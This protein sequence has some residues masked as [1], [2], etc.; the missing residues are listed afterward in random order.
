MGAFLREFDVLPQLAQAGLLG[1]D[2]VDDF[3]A[4]VGLVFV[5]EAGGEHLLLVKLT[6][7]LGQLIFEEIEIFECIL[8][9]RG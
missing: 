7:Q 2:R 9:S 5:V 8:D 4:V 6:L 3:L 1:L